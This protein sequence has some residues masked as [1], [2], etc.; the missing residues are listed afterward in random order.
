MIPSMPKGATAIRMGMAEQTRALAQPIQVF[1]GTS[2][3]LEK[4]EKDM[5]RFSS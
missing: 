2:S 3:L 4:R 5:K 1:L